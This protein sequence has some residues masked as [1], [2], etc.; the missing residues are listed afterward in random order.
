MYPH[1]SQSSPS[2]RKQPHH[3]LLLL[4]VSILFLL[5]HSQYL[6]SITRWCPMRIQLFFPCVSVLCL[7]SFSECVFPHYTI[8]LYR[9]GGPAI[10]FLGFLFLLPLPSFQTPPP[11]PICHLPFYRCAQISLISFP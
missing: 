8:L 1:P 4:S 7:N 6:P 3:V 5:T 2:R 9:P 10:L 11:L